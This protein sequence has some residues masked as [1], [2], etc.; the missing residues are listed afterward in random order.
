ML[1]LAGNK[2]IN[3]DGANIFM[4]C[5]DKMKILWLHG[6][7]LSNKMKSKL[8]EKGKEEKCDVYVAMQ[9]LFEK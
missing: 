8:K 4:E 7:N 5:F 2:D 6:C 9:L 3:D 1:N